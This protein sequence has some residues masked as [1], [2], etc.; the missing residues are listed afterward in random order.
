MQYL[1]HTTYLE[2]I[3]VIKVSIYTILM[4]YE[5]VRS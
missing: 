3:F 2:L 5:Q 4:I 1:K